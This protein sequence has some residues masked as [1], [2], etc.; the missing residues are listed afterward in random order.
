MPDSN[1]HSTSTKVAPDDAATGPQRWDASHG[2]GAGPPHVP[3]HRAAT[4]S[5]PA[6]SSVSSK[7]AADSDRRNGDPTA[8]DQT[9][10]QHLPPKLKLRLR[11][12]MDE[13][14]AINEPEVLETRPGDLVEL[15]PE[16]EG[17]AGVPESAANDEMDADAPIDRQMEPDPVSS[18]AAVQDL[19]GPPELES[20]E[21]PLPSGAVSELAPLEID[22][23]PT[24]ARVPDQDQPSPPPQSLEPID[25][26]EP[27][28]ELASIEE[29][30]PVEAPE[31]KPLS[32]GTRTSDPDDFPSTLPLHATERSDQDLEPGP[33]GPVY[34]AISEISA[35]FSRQAR[36]IV[37]VL[38]RRQAHLAYQKNQLELREA[39]LEKQLRLER[40]ALAEKQ[41]QYQVAGAQPADER[42][43]EPVDSTEVPD[44]APENQDQEF[45]AAVQSYVDRFPDPDTDTD[46]DMVDSAAGPGDPPSTRTNEPSD[47]QGTWQQQAKQLRAQHQSAIKAMRQ[48]RRQLELLKNV[49]VQQQ[50]QWSQRLEELEQE[51][52]RWRSSQQ[53]Q[54]QMWRT[55]HQEIERLRS[56]EIN[57]TSKREH[58]LSQREAAIRALEE[59]LQQA[60]VEILRDRVIIKQLE[61]TAR[62]SL[63]NV[64]W[65]QRRQIIADET[66]AYIKKVQQ[67]AESTQAETERG[68][69]KLESRQ[70]EMLLYRESLRNWIQRQM[71]LVSRRS[72]H[73]EEREEGIEQNLTELS[74]GRQSLQEQQEVLHR[75]IEQGLDQIDRH[76]DRIQGPMRATDAA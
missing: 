32:G 7:Q 25:G 41:R 62:Q 53:E 42:A 46:S 74:R 35:A 39:S 75:M 71:K 38:K 28:E 22:P 18:L 30:E 60:Q 57:E 50:E 6:D 27:I 58:F 54:Q 56:L 24:S 69:E 21:P 29:L 5:P 40:L 12:L 1:P 20:Q 19:A 37:D 70:A 55:A 13:L 23:Q 10:D 31:L 66:E 48:T 44:G 76:L 4:E 67:E 45:F 63:S 43:E 9:L 52:S 2:R 3:F 59:K 17:V 33:Q 64:D 15:P 16:S 61:R 8:L 72:A 26:Q 36:E 49:I 73:L 14:A 51:Q 34:P 68:L 47:D 65:N 11:Q